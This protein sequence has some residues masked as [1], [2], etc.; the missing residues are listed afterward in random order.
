[1]DPLRLE[2]LPRRCP[3]WS[4]E[5]EGAEV[6]SKSRISP[7]EKAATAKVPSKLNTIEVSR[8][9]IRKQLE[10]EQGSA[11]EE[12]EGRGGS[13]FSWALDELPIVEEEEGG[14]GRE[15]SESTENRLLLSSLITCSARSGAGKEGSQ[16]SAVE[17][18]SSL[19]N[20]ELLIPLFRTISS[21]LCPLLFLTN[22]FIPQ[23]ADKTTFNQYYSIFES[24]GE[25][26]KTPRRKT[27]FE[28]G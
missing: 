8:V 11:V 23:Q 13:A 10:L 6:M 9:S 12:L 22:K 14:S 27:F 7:E 1:M 28:N 20:D 3:Y 24:L 5:E 21:K 17:G 2:M 18:R 16:W 25:K 26:R 19:D 15:D 4:V